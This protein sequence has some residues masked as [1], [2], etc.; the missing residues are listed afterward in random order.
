[1]LVQIN[2]KLQ[3]KSLKIFN[4]KVKKKRRQLAIRGILKNGEWIEAPDTVKEEFLMHFSNRFKQVVGLSPAI[5]SLSFNSLSQSHCDYLELPFSREEIKRAVWDCGGDRAPGP[6]GFTF[7]FFTTFWDTIE[8]DVVSFVQEFSTFHEIPKGCNPSFIALIRK[9]SNAKFVSDFQPISLIGCQYKIIGKLLANRLSNVIRDCISPVQSA[10]IKVRYILDGPLILNEVLVEYRK[11]HKELLVFKVDFEKAFDSLRWDFLDAVMGKIGFGIKWRSWISGCLRNAR[12]SV[13]VNGSPTKEFELFKGLR[14]G[15]P[16]SPFLFILAMEGLHSLTCKAEELGLFKG[17]TSG[18]DNT[19]IS[20]LINVLGV[21]V[22]DEE[23][24]HMAH[25]IGCGV[26]RLLFKYLGKARF[27]SVGGRLSLIK[28]VLG[29]LP[30]YFMSIY[31]MPVSIRSKLESMRSKFF[32]GADQNDNK[33][34]WVKW[35]RCFASK[36][37]GGLGIGSI[38]GLNIGLLFKWIWRFLTRPSELWAHVIRSIYG[39]HGGIFLANNSRH[40]QTTWGYILSSVSRLKDNGIDLLSLCSRKL[41]NGK[42]T[43]FWEDTWCGNIPLKLQFPRIYNLETDRNCLIANRVPLLHSDWSTVLRRIPR[44]GAESAQFNALKVAIGNVS[45]T[46]QCD[47][48]QWSL[49]VDWSTVLRRIPRGGAESAQLD[50]LKVAIRN[51][52]LTDQCDSW[53]WSLGVAAGFS[54]A[55]VRTLVDDT[56]LEAGLVAIRWIRNIPI[57]V[58]VFIW[59][60]SLNKLPSRVNLDRRGIEVASTLCPTCQLDVETVNHIFFN[61]DMARDLWSLLAKWW[62]L[63]ILICASITDWYDLLDDVRISAK[64]RL[65][66]EGVGGLSCGLFGIFGTN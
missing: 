62:E 12:S 8:E 23:I 40:K 26:S 43:C 17:A 59:R 9:V 42:S 22:S 55:S 11:H 47:S 30:T 49:G 33:M 44:G 38:Y 13:L 48:W 18:R 50:A 34:S 3:T 45:L 24:S 63:D 7:S 37:K 58:N 65:I 53:Q 36:K 4:V 25:I 19:S 1:M 21:G 46:D 54:V 52:S 56:T 14:Q 10:F 5:D 29:N 20:H 2:T 16:L 32:R 15:D 64:A 51:V 35:E 6:D 61:Y 66:L 60:L 41:G 39:H 28:A 27:L 57:K 31:L